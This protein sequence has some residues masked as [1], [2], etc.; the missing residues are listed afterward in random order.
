MVEITDRLGVPDITG[1]VL[2]VR[3]SPASPEPG[4]LSDAAMGTRTGAGEGGS[5][6]PRD[7]GIQPRGTG[8]S[9]LDVRTGAEL[10]RRDDR[11]DL[12]VR[13]AGATHTG[14]KREINQDAY[15]VRFPLFVVADGMGGHEAGEVASAAVVERLDESVLN[16][17]EPAEEQLTNALRRAV[18]DMANS[19]GDS[20]SGT[21]TTMTGVLHRNTHDGDGEWSVLNIGDSR[22]YRLCDGVLEQISTDH[23][24][25]Q[26]LLSAGA[27]TEEEAEVHPHRNVITRAV[28]LIDDPIPDV[29]LIDAER[30]ARWLVC[31]DGLTKEL[32]DYGIQHFLST[33]PSPDQAI[34]AM[35]VA[36]LNNGGRD[37]VT[38]IV[39]DEILQD[40]V[41]DDEDFGVPVQI[42]AADAA[43]AGAELA[44]VD[45][46]LADAE[47]ADSAAVAAVA[48]GSDAA[49]ASA[50]GEAPL[51]R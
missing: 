3:I 47:L 31:S 28:G 13:W 44:D 23:S 25:V 39:F 6:D 11:P 43:D 36:A 5:G 45:A 27:I 7:Y 46:A 42:D 16:H 29:V 51:E 20:G 37:N 8:V 12:L 41:A 22:V 10:I 19:V 15:L 21:G 18:V 35:F 24:V 4:I 14:R 33:M 17:P 32:T 9:D 2:A 49:D 38:A 1:T 40:G 26:E 48:E 34:N 30:R 50:H